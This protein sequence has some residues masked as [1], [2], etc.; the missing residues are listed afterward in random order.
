MTLTS[1]DLSPYFLG[2]EPERLGKLAQG[3]GAYGDLFVED[4]AIAAVRLEGG[5]VVRAAR[6]RQRGFA[7]RSVSKDGRTRISSSTAIDAS[8]AERLAKEIAFPGSGPVAAFAEHRAIYVSSAKI[9]PESVSFERR[10]ELAELADHIARSLSPAI[11]EVSVTV[12]D[13]IR[14]TGIA[15]S[16]GRIVAQEH[17]RA[18]VA[19]EAIAGDGDRTESAYEAAGGTGGLELIS[20]EE[21]EKCARLAAARALRML[22]AKPAPAGEM[23]VVLAAEAG[24]TFVH[25]AVGHS[26][27]ADLVLEGLSA[28]GDRIGE[29]VA[30]EKITVLDDATISE[31]NGTFSIDDEGVLAERT[32]IIDRGILVSLLYDERTALVL[33]AKSG[34]KGRRESFRDRPM[35]RMTNTMIAPGTDDPAAILR[36]TSSGLYVVRMGGGEVDTIT[37]QFV[38]EVSEAYLIENGAIGEPVRGA[39]LAGDCLEVLESIDRVGSDLGFGVGT[40]GKDG[41]DVPISDAEPTIRIPALVVGGS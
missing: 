33:G 35:V 34:G 1:A 21:I 8:G 26:L 19:V 29:R 31:K 11:R 20:E 16:D 12:R 28:L 38:F 3:G 15:G 23:T 5:A 18:M 14:R 36:D 39:T 41:Q 25:E 24:G 40:C 6:D 7:A 27:E 22:F 10:I 32:K 4:H 13:S 37:G 9:R 30:S 2:L 17:V